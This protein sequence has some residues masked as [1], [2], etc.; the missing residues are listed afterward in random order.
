MSLTINESNFHAEVIAGT[1]E[2]F[3]LDIY[4]PTCGPCRLLSPIIDRLTDIPGVK[5]GKMD[6]SD[7]YDFC[8]N[9]GVKAVPTLLFYKGG[10]VVHDMV[11]VVSEQVLRAKL[12]ELK[13]KT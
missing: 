1:Q 6:M 13:R 8:V 11:G 7:N 2:V 10:K 12:E 4:T 5:V 9:V 3:L